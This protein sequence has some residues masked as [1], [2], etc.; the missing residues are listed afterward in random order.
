[1]DGETSLYATSIIKLKKWVLVIRE[2]P[3]EEL[4]PLLQARFLA[5][6]IALGGVVLIIIGAVLHHPGHDEGTD[7]DGPEEGGQR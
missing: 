4:T 5:A 6:L 2:A 7:A 3:T 1:M